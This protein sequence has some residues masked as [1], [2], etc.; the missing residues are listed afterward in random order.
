MVYLL[1]RSNR[2][3]EDKHGNRKMAK[4]QTCKDNTRNELQPPVNI[5]PHRRP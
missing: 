2:G 4:V 1:T 5:S 3:R